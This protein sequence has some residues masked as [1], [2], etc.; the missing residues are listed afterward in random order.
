MKFNYQA[1]TKDGRLQEGIVEA[2]ARDEAVKTL[3][4]HDLVILELKADD[5]S[6]LNKNISFFQ[7]IKQK[8]VVVFSRELAVLVEGKV[9]IVEALKS[10]AHQTTNPMMRQVVSQLA[11][12]V[13]G[14][15][16]LARAFGK[17]TK[18]FSEFYINLLRSAEVSGTLEQSLLYLADY[19]EKR[20]ETVSKIKGALTY[21]AFVITAS[22]IVGVLMMIFV[23]PQITQILVDAGGSLP[24]PT[25]ILIFTSDLMRNN[26]AALL[27]TLIAG[28][29]GFWYYIHTPKGKRVWHRVVLYLPLFGPVFRKFYLERIADNLST[30]LKG[31]ISIIK[32]L[33]TT[34]KVTGNSIFQDII[35]EAKEEVKAGKSIS[36]VLEKH[37]EFPPMFVELT[38]V[39]EH[40][41][42]L[43]TILRR[44]AT[45][46]NKEVASVMD[47][48]TKLI[49]PLLVV[50][51]GLGVAL[52]MS[53][54]LLPIY[55]LT[56]NF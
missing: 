7:R 6:L 42:N 1:R 51:L 56:S 45:F 4:D 33:D 47:N 32:A 8:D 2:A 52:L 49:E 5:A 41:G 46:Y 21:P 54:V 26:W 40:S 11:K 20:L 3:H 22:V 15:M 50:V 31:G 55:N 9:P 23:V 17:H 29:A 25:R 14:G 10:L 16:S 39:G 44:L 12:D 35:L 30:L 24:L 27:I 38:K 19:E 36:S 28:G 34:A 18:V 53:A 37:Q 48:L 13:E 43:D